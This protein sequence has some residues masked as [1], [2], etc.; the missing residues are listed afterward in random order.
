MRSNAK[1]SDST[2]RRRSHAKN[3]VST[4]KKAY[5]RILKGVITLFFRIIMPFERRTN[6]F[7]KALLHFFSHYYAFWKA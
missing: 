1:H 2:P 7:W 3:S 5:K 4:P 6:A